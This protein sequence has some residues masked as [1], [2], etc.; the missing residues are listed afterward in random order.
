MRNSSVAPLSDMGGAMK[1]S[2]TPSTFGTSVS[3]GFEVASLAFPGPLAFFRI[4]MLVPH[5]PIAS[6]P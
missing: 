5:T 6:K 4:T 2:S 3:R 1:S